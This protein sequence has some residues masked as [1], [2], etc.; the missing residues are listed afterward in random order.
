MTYNVQAIRDAIHASVERGNDECPWQKPNKDA[1]PVKTIYGAPKV[2]ELWNAVYGAAGD[3][4]GW[5]VNIVLS[6]ADDLVEGNAPVTLYD[7]SEYAN[8][9]ADVYYSAMMFWLSNDLN[10]T[11]WDQVNEC[12]CDYLQDAQ[13]DGLWR[14]I[15]LAQY[16]IAENVIFACI[17]WLEEYGET[18]S[19]EPQVSAND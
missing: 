15:P 11:R 3:L 2:G 4:D 16:M 8:S 9:F 18:F 7:T 1:E 19:D 13:D 14:I 10:S 17:E 6:W 12:L 5:L